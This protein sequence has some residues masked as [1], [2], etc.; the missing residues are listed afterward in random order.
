[1]FLILFFLTIIVIFIIIE[2]ATIAFNLTGLN[3]EAS[4][5]QAIS[6]V[7]NTGFT[8]TEAELI[9]RHRVRRKI[10]YFLMGT[11]YVSLPVLITL[12]IMILSTGFS[13]EELLVLIAFLIF[14]MFFIRNKKV[15]GVIEKGIK[16][17]IIR[18]DIVPAS[19][20]EDLFDLKGN[21]KIVKTVMENSSLA[22]KKI[23]EIRL[24]NIDITILAIERGNKLFRTVKGT[25][26]L[27]I[28]DKLILYG[29]I[30]SI[31]NVFD[32][33]RPYQ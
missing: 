25:D 8:T 4:R 27:E 16:S 19:S 24:N 7:T 1:M 18:Y 20:I 3:K 32:S 28:G 14:Y 12:L 30:N 13:R 22:G 29:N 17:I 23:S 33:F 2:F 15:M 5:F 26:T 31:K 10:A 21:Y 11:F 9:V 6:L